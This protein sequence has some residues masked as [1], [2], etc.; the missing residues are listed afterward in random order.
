MDKTISQLINLSGKTA[1]VTGGAKGIGLGIVK[2]LHE[3]GA[4]IVI[5]DLDTIGSDETDKLNAA[6]PESAVF[7]KVDVSSESD[8]KSAIELAVNSFGSLDIMVN[9]AGIFP[10]VPLSQLDQSLF[11]KVI[12]I[13][14]K[15]VFLGS[16]LAS[17]QMIAQKSGGSIITITSIDPVHLIFS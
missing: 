11:S 9:N 10:F 3:A 14:L 5:A 2:R 16:K 15:G 6:R 1:L 4:N 7:Q 12:D 8:I 13:N 17:G